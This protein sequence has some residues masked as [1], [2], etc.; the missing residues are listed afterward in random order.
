[1]SG[2]NPNTKTVRVKVAT[3]YLVAS[4]TD[5]KMCAQ[6]QKKLW[7]ARSDPELKP[8]CAILEKTIDFLIT[9]PKTAESKKL[10][11]KPT[12]LDTNYCLG[13]RMISWDHE[14]TK[15][16][17][18]LREWHTEEREIELPK[19]KQ[20]L[21]AEPEEETEPADEAPATSPARKRTR[22]PTTKIK[23]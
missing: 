21:E 2:T 19:P 20:V 15:F 10:P 13:D 12:L 5:E 16:T 1:M 7:P 3:W 4:C 14:F 22:K 6:V 17:V 11:G 18:Q 9:N 8:S 23:K